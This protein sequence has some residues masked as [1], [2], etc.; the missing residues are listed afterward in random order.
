MFRFTFWFRVLLYFKHEF[1]K[2]G[3]VIPYYILR[4]YEYKYGIHANSNINVGEGLHIVHGDGIH[5]NCKEIGRNFTVYQGVTLGVDKNG[6]I[7]TICDNVSIYPNAV[8]VGDII[9]GNGATIGANSFVNRDVACG[10]VIAGCPA[11]SIRIKNK[12]E[13]NIV[14]SD[15]GV[16][17]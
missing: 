16:M 3:S 12:N 8:V 9:I 5:L 14:K 15:E 13:E 1:G 2:Y 7:P 17:F 6:G 10:D 11:K 4:H